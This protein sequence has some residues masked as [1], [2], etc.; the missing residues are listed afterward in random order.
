MRTTTI[1]RRFLGALGAA[2]LGLSLAACNSPSTLA[3]AAPTPT[4]TPTP[5]PQPTAY[6]S[7]SYRRPYARPEYTR[8]APKK[9]SWQKSALII[10]GSAGTGALIGG[11]AGGK[12]GAAIGALAGGAGGF[13][14]DQATRNH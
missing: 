4:P 7:R 2:A 10:G 8:P 3:A 11:I 5:T 1:S 12:K 14:Y 6:V 9:R 13:I